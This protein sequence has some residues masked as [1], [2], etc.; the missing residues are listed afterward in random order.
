MNNEL[1]YIDK[2]P[3]KN[4]ETNK[5]DMIILNERENYLE[6]K[7]NG[8]NEYDSFEMF[9]NGPGKLVES[10]LYYGIN[11][12]G[13]PITFFNANIKSTSYR[14]ISST[15]ITSKMYAI[16]RE[17]VEPI[18]H[19]TPK[20]KIKKFDYYNDKLIYYYSDNPISIKRKGIK[21][22]IKIKA[23]TNKPKKLFTLK[24][25]NNNEISV[26]L[27]HSFNP[28]GSIY[29]FSIK[30]NTYLQIRFKKGVSIDD[31][32][33]VSNRIDSTLHMCILNRNKSYI[34][35]IYDYSRRSYI[36]YNYRQK[37][38]TT[39][40][41][42]TFNICKEKKELN[43][44]FQK[45]LLLFI[46]IDFENSNTYLPFINFNRDI[47]YYEMEF[48]Q[49]YKV[50]EVIDFE[51]QKIKEKRKDR[52]FLRKYLTKY[53]KLKD[54][55]FKETD[56]DI[57]ESEIRSLRNYYSHDGFYADKLP[58]PTDKPRYYKNITIQWLYDVKRLVK[59]IAYNEIYDKANVTIDELELI[60][61]LY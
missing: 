49:Y 36:F 46:N 32:L 7:V 19:I 43:T 18:K 24:Y 3:F 25:R 39:E 34:T 15:T 52:R 60:N 27:I 53:S 47:N 42:P 33:H 50:L 10:K 44:I 6:I 29:D 22:E 17:V 21:D 59:I 37:K 57:L 38:Y 5:Q 23:K 41:M 4:I 8:I 40:K 26:Y 45:L 31:V 1:G 13:Y 16:G 56:V 55:F 48:L 2:K 51:K 58:I 61:H 35:T 12:K 9:T 54:Y 20:T 11:S 28:D 30:P 14:L